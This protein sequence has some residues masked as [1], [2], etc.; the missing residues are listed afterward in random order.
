MNFSL[1]ANMSV[2]AQTVTNVM[3]P[4]PISLHKTATS[5]W[6]FVCALLELFSTW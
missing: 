4:N 1:S 2:F 6:L 3:Y 5:Q